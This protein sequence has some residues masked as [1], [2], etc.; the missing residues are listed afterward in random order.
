MIKRIFRIG[1]LIPCLYYYKRMKGSV[2]DAIDED[3]AA[4]IRFMSNNKIDFR[5]L[6]KKDKGRMFLRL[7]SNNQDFRN[8]FYYRLLESKVPVS[9]INTLKW[10]APPYPGLYMSSPATMEIEPGG[11]VFMHPFSSIVNAKKIGKGCIIRH[12]TTIGNTNEVLENIPTIGNKVNI[13]AG[14][15]IIG[16][17]TIGSNVIIGAGSVVV[18]DVPDNCVVAGNPARILRELK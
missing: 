8:V 11:I 4:Y 3:I 17:I 5:Q 7:M 2:C 16:K 12:N 6:S 9:R 15:I 13:G 14:A 1:K 18:K 10:L